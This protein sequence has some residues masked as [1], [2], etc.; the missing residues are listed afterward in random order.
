MEA[1][2]EARDMYESSKDK[3]PQVAR[4]WFISWMETLRIRMSLYGL[5]TM[6]IGPLT[7]INQSFGGIEPEK[8]DVATG[9]RLAAVMKRQHEKKLRA[10]N[11]GEV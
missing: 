3:R 10:S 11:E 7:Q 6:K 5:D 9:E 2:Q 4:T 8:I 1:S